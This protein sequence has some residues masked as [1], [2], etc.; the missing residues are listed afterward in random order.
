MGCSQ[1]QMNVTKSGFQRVFACIG[2]FIEGTEILDQVKA[3]METNWFMG[4]LSAT[5]GEKLLQTLQDKSFLVRFSP[6]SGEFSISFKENN[7][8]LHTRVLNEARFNLH[9]YVQM[10]IAKKGFKQCP[11]SPFKVTDATSQIHEWKFIR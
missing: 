2:P 10:L 9:N 4:S 8:I 6:N 7:K 1:T 3:L 11:P 5:E